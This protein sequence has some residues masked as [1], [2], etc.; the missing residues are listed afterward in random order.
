MTFVL[1]TNVLSELR[2]SDKADAKAAI[3]V[4]YTL[5]QAKHVGLADPHRRRP[6]SGTGG[7]AG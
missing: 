4:P 5:S 6:D 3:P 2:R 7:I 1:D